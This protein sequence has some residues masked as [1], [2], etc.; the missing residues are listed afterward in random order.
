M[1]DKRKTCETKITVCGACLRAS[2]WQGVFYCD[3]YK[4]AGVVKLCVSA[5]QALNYE[6]PSYWCGEHE[7]VPRD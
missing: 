3:D 4:K 7:E 5:L 1:G 6:N 2:C